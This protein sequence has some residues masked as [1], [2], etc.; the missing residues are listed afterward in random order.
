[1]LYRTF[2]LAGVRPTV[3]WKPN[4]FW[5]GSKPRRAAEVN[6]HLFVGNVLDEWAG[7]D[8]RPLVIET[9]LIDTAAANADRRLMSRVLGVVFSG[10]RV[11]E[12]AGVLEVT[13]VCA[14]LAVRGVGLSRVAALAGAA[15]SPVA[16][17]VGV[18]DQSGGHLW[19]AYDVDDD[20]ASY[21]DAEAAFAAVAPIGNVFAG[22]LYLNAE[23]LAFLR[24]RPGGEGPAR[25]ARMVE[26]RIRIARAVYPRTMIV[27]H[28][29]TLRKELGV[30]EV[31]RAAAAYIGD[32][33]WAA[34]L[35]AALGAGGDVCW[36]QHAQAPVLARAVDVAAV[37]VKA[38]AEVR[39]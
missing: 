33:Y 25:F 9:E 39:R 8:T 2:E 7:G 32:D 21:L 13:A 12:P 14:Q 30:I 20:P 16:R 29:T 17:L 15:R 35:G 36:W 11:A 26:G 23:R 5:G 28:H 27:L 19:R 6:W 22:P 1:M 38:N 37:V 34:A 4:S 10:S 31:E 24:S 3:C 18:F